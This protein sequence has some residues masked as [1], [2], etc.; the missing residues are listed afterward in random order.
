[1]ASNFLII[2][3]IFHL[4]YKSKLPMKISHRYTVSKQIIGM[5]GYGLANKKSG[6][7]DAA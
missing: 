1:M 5:C 3:I 4:Y 6:T 7:F 2:E